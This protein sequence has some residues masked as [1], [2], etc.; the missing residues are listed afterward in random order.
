MIDG[1]TKVI[2]HSYFHLYADDL[3]IYRP[4]SSL[5]DASL[6]QID[7]DCIQQWLISNKLSF[8][9]QKCEYV[10]YSKRRNLIPSTYNINSIPLN[11]ITSK[12]DLGVTFS[13]DLS[14]NS[15]IHIITKSCYRTLGFLMRI[16]AVIWTPQTQVHMKQLESVQATFCRTLFLKLNFFLSPF[17]LLPISI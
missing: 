1:I 13:Q 2:K 16:A 4:I 10:T 3:K 11:K 15:H 17:N 5:H 8:C 12:K 9:P 7:L 14:F 6:L